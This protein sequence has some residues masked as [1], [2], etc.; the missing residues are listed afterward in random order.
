MSTAL[1]SRTWLSAITLVCLAPLILTRG[2][3]G[4][5]AEPDSGS[6]FGRVETINP[7]FD[8]RAWRA[9]WHWD[10]GE[11]T[12]TVFTL[13]GDTENPIEAITV[14]D[15]LGPRG[16]SAAPL[17]GILAL[18]AAT[19]RD[20]PDTTWNLIRETETDVM[21]EYVQAGCQEQVESDYPYTITRILKGSSGIHQIV[22]GTHRTLSEAKRL[23]W[24]DRIGRAELMLQLAIVDYSKGRN[25]VTQATRPVRIDGGWLGIQSEY[26]G[27]TETLGRSM[28]SALSF[29]V[30]KYRG[31]Y[32]VHL[33]NETDEPVWA[34]VHWY[35]PHK[36]KDKL[37]HKTK[38]VQEVKPGQRKSVGMLMN[39]IV[40][41]KKIPLTII[42]STDK[43]QQ[44]I[45]Y[46]EETYMFFPGADVDIFKQQYLVAMSGPMKWPRLYGWPEMPLP[47]T[48]IPGTFA[49][50]G[51]RTDIQ[52]NLW[53]EQSKQYR[54]CNHET[55]R[56]ES[57]DDETSTVAA[58]PM[59]EASER[60]EPAP[61][62]KIVL[63]EFWWVRSCDVTSKYEVLLAE[64]SDGA[65]DMIITK[66][67]ETDSGA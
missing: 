58:S 2:E 11:A 65:A 66:I 19:L 12:I 60:G 21:A 63:R 4:A 62:S 3:L 17:D 40:A 49:E 10:E 1:S 39:Y 64:S 7:P 26:I 34:K 38:K 31:E 48:N 36:N 37:S 15:F 46:T 22:Y 44:D 25:Y 32:Y 14:Q 33:I 13:Y 9:P 27:D 24:V 5:A 23:E 35:F 57:I 6:V 41:D 18:K 55:L 30:G 16:K 20:C 54:E 45:L 61:T 29:G 52:F 8:D 50:L 59:V 53:K 42:I 67:E 51:L 47:R 43:K 28:G 56:A